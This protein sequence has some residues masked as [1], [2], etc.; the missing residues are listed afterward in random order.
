[1]FGS[2]LVVE[3][4]LVVV[5]SVGLDVIVVVSCLGVVGFGVGLVGISGSVVLVVN[6]P[7]SKGVCVSLV[8][9]VEGVSV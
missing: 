8:H 2:T 4:G 3:L 1:M 5:A 6:R 9:W 7:S